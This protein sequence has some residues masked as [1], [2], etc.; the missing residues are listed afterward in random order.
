MKP[1]H[2]LVAEH[3]NTLINNENMVRHR[4][5]NIY[6][7]DATNLEWYYDERKFRESVSKKNKVGHVIN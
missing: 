4:D 3:F 6:N 7:N 1:V 5:G 2:R